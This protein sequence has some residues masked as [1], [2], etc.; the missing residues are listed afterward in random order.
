MFEVCKFQD[1]ST[2]SLKP[3]ALDV[4]SC[5]YTSFNDPERQLHVRIYGVKVAYL[6]NANPNKISVLKL[7]HYYGT[8]MHSTK[9]VSIYLI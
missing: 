2:H 6:V 7:K 5:P 1:S 8:H 3:N 9:E 4:K